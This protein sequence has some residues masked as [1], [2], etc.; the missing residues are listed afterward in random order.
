MTDLRIQPTAPAALDAA[1]EKLRATA[2]QFEGL[3]LAQLFKEMRSSVEQ[4]AVDSGPGQEMFSGMFDETMAMEAG[5]RSTH[6]LGEALYRQLAARLD[7]TKASE[8]AK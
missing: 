8:G 7:Q 4:D 6:G 2:H 5:K 1:H 3:F